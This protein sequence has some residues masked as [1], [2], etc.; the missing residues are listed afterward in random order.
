MQPRNRGH[1]THQTLAFDTCMAK[2][3][4]WCRPKKEKR[5]EQDQI[6]VA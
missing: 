1:E 6:Y 4:F 5:F 3:L 2:K